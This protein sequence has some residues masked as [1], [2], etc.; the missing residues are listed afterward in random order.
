MNKDYCL[1][2]TKVVI[3]R[4]FKQ[5]LEDILSCY[6]EYK[7]LYHNPINTNFIENIFLYGEI[8]GAYLKNNII[9]CCYYFPM[10]SEFF[11]TSAFCKA[12]EDFIDC[13]EKYFYMGYVGI[14]YDTISPCNAECPDCPTESGLYQAFMNIAQMQAFRRGFRYIVHASPVKLKPCTETFFTSGYRLI[15]MRGLENLVVHYIFV[16]PVFNEENIYETDR[17]TSPRKILLENTKKV[18]ALLENGYCGV[19]YSKNDNI[20]YMCRLIAD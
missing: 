10:D 13:T 7:S 14:K 11:R 12:M 17:S 16:K 9:G 6:E 8:W 18:S 15:K 19:D 4:L 20:M 1:T 5:D 3:R 2:G